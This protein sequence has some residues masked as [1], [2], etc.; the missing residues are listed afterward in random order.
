V[1]DLQALV[2]DLRRGIGHFDEGDGVRV[3]SVSTY[4]P[5]V[6]VASVRVVTR[7]VSIAVASLSLSLSLLAGAFSL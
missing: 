2:L 7:C 4:V 6:V 3:K 5:G 1:V